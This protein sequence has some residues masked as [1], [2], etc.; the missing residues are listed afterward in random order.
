VDPPAPPSDPPPDPPPAPDPAPQPPPGPT[1]PTAD[2]LFRQDLVQELRLFLNSADWQA[3]KAGWQSN[4]YY[5][6]D[7]HWNGLVAYNIGIR[8]RGGGSRSPIK[9]GLRLDFD[10]YASEQEFLGFKS[11]VLDNL[12]QDPSMLKERV[13]MALFSRMSLAAPRVV[14]TRLFVNNADVGLYTLVEPVDKRFLAR[15]LGENDGFLFEAIAKDNYGFQYLG[16]DPLIY[17]SFFEPK[18]H[19]RDPAWTLYAPIETMVRT[20]EDAP[21]ASFADDVG[22]Y[23]DLPRF[24]RHVAVETF[25]AEFDGI[26]GNWGLNNYYLYRFEQRPLA[27]VLPWDK[28]FTFYAIDLDIWRNVDAN[29]LMNR[30]MR[31]PTLR[32]RY[33]EA[34]RECA[35]L[36]MT[37]IPAPAPSARAVDPAPPPPPPG[38]FEAEILR[39]A[40]QIRPWA[41]ADARKP[42]DNE[43]FE[44]ELAKVLRF[45]RERAG[46]VLREVAKGAR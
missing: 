34:L 37:P 30:A 16:S 6:A 22:V 38:W 21:D 27:R 1:G 28:D 10:R 35:T 23:L 41:L 13:A 17:A 7:L 24:I 43:R 12:T 2:D 5:P 4:T 29:A 39:L 18:T 40:D 42:F 8:S 32:G 14:H 31:D 3:L 19:E 33:L 26:L 11:L 36:A 25:L 20:I 9:P 46:F 45:A 44:D 15:H